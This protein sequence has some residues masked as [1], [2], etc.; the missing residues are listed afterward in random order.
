MTS[1][2]LWIKGMK[3]EQSMAES[4]AE[5]KCKLIVIDGLD[6]SGKATQTAEL[7]KRLCAE[8]YKART[9]S[10]P[11]YESDGSAAVR[12][13]L[14]GR[15]GDSPDDVNAYAASSFYAVDRV[16]SYLNG[17]GRDYRTFDFIVAD[18]YV[19]SNIIHQMAKLGADERDDYIGW[20]YDY[21]YRRLGIPEPDLVI[22]LDVDP[23]ISQKLMLGRYHGDESKK[24]IHESNVRYLMGCRE[25]AAYAI[26]KLGWVRIRCDDG[27]R[28]RT[29]SDIS[30]ELYALI[31]ERFDA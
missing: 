10:F 3:C 12:M 27:E 24:D 30:D 16:V 28:M 18:R 25:S 8:G 21:E 17:W 9:L 31:K 5:K 2:R 6:G 11:D 1:L 4:M 23:A 19:T 20:L 22:F 15:L 7:C 14:S 13:Y 29:V 26:E